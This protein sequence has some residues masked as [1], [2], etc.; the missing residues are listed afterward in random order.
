MLQIVPAALEHQCVHA[1]GVAVTRQ[2]TALAHPQQV[3]VIAA[4]DAQQQGLERYRSGHRDPQL[5]VFEPLAEYTGVDHVG[6]HER[7]LR[8]L[9]GDGHFVGFGGNAHEGFH[10]WVS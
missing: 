7:Y 2:H 4:R 8:Q 1:A 6:G 3:D 10:S 5:V 9:I